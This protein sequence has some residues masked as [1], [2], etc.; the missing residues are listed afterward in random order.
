MPSLSHRC[1]VYVWKVTPRDGGDDFL[2]KLALE[3]GKVAGYRI[4]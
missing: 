2:I 3:K 4:F 1:E